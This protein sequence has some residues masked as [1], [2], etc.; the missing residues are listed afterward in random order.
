M[1]R[2]D[3]D[4]LLADVDLQDLADELLGARQ[5]RAR[6]PT[7]PCPMPTHAQTGRTPPVTIFTTRWGEQRW[8]CHG[9]GACGTAIDLVMQARNVPVREAMDLLAGRSCQHSRRDSSPPAPGRRPPV[10]PSLPHPE[11]DTYAAECERLLWT[12]QGRSARRWLVDTRRLSEDVLRANRVGYDPGVRRLD[13]PDGLPRPPGVV[14]PVLDEDGRAVFTQTRRLGSVEGPRYL[15]CAS[16]AA[17]NPRMASYQLGSVDAGSRCL[18]VCEGAI[19]AL[20]AA[21]AGH[22]AVAI[23]GTSLADDRVASRLAMGTRRPVIAFDADEA[24]DLAAGRLI[25]LLQ[26]RGVDARRLRPP[27]Q[28]GDLNAWSIHGGNRFP[29]DLCREVRRSCTRTRHI[30]ESS[31]VHR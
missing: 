18:I 4:A 3:R 10:V 8:H 30:V 25:G 28:V 11:I 22:H 19:D 2:Y 9:C 6:S 1:S 12:P 26:G 31:S 14:L 21:S 15:N 16:R 17:P 5:G 20:S 29:A 23:L 24:G 27:G 13:R 7:W